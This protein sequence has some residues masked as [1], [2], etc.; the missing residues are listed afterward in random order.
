[1]L[2]EVG[3]SC[4]HASQSSGAV[5]QGMGMAHKAQRVSIKD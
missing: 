2:P 3:H 4:R 1:L 5:G